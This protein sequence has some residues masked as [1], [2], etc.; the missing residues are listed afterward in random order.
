[1]MAGNDAGP[2]KGTRGTTK[3][4]ARRDLESRGRDATLNDGDY[5]DEDEELQGDRHHLDMRSS[6]DDKIQ[7]DNARAKKP[8]PPNN[9]GNNRDTPY[10][11]RNGN[12]DNGNNRNVHFQN[13]APIQRQ[14]LHNTNKRSGYATDDNDNCNDDDN[15]PISKRGI[16]SLWNEFMGRQFANAEETLATP[17]LAGKNDLTQFETYPQDILKLAQKAKT[18]TINFEA[19]A[20]TSGQF[21]MDKFSEI[22]SKIASISRLSALSIRS[23]YSA[24]S[25]PNLVTHVGHALAMAASAYKDNAP[26]HLKNPKEDD[27]MWPVDSDLR[28]SWPMDKTCTYAQQAAASLGIYTRNNGSNGNHDSRS[29]FRPRN[30]NS[31]YNFGSVYDPSQGGNI[32]APPPR[33]TG[34]SFPVHMQRHQRR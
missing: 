20:T 15:A 10:Q 24:A 31:N 22:K 7:R 27:K 13:N 25:H 19:N 4:F 1:M 32:P 5:E 11:F 3:L 23:L 12:N 16:F 28:D 21:D 30:F 2:S 17:S 33:M 8:S 26:A 18:L 14:E 6:L 29:Q 34:G 9:L